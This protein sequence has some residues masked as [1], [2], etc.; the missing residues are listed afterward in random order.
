MLAS[1]GAI[2][3]P[4]SAWAFEPK[5]DGWRVLVYVCDKLEVRTRGG[6]DVAMAVPELAPLV[7]ALDG[8]QV[9]LDGELV[10]RQGRPWGFYRLGPRLAARRPEAVT[11]QRARTAVTLA[12][13]DVLEL[14]G[15][16]LIA[17]PYAERRQRLEELGLTGS[18]WCTVSSFVGLGPELIVACAQMGLE[19][20]VAKRLDSRYRPGA[21]S[22]DWVK[23]KCPDWR[24]THAPRRL[25]GAQQRPE[26]MRTR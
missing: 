13:F 23:V 20:L 1:T 12:I 14:D 26:G 18:A 17:R 6:H 9:I 11:R 16:S 8:R 15:E 25:D 3:E 21:R 19:G 7:D 4:A 5:L 2:A 10:A 24:A 22:K